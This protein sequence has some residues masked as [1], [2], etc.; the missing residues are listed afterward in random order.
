MD[1]ARSS[2]PSFTKKIL[3]HMK[4]NHKSKKVEVT[5]NSSDSDEDADSFNTSIKLGT[6]RISLPT[7]TK[8]QKKTSFLNQRKRRRESLPIELTIS[9]KRASNHNFSS[10]VPSYK[11]IPKFIEVCSSYQLETCTTVSENNEFSYSSKS[12]NQIDNCNVPLIIEESDAEND[13]KVENESSDPEDHYSNTQLPQLNINDSGSHD[14]ITSEKTPHISQ[15]P[16]NSPSQSSL[17]NI[18]TEIKSTNIPSV[19][20]LDQALQSATLQNLTWN[21]DIKPINSQRKTI[22]V[23]TIEV[24]YGTMMVFFMIDDHKSLIFINLRHKLCSKIQTGV[25]LVFCHDFPPYHL[26]NIDFYTG[27]SK[28]KLMD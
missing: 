14:T 27:I 5:F 21:S 7:P 1:S 13:V 25:E 15:P 26:N 23:S 16:S 4:E 11:S 3:C 18:Y 2:N 10:A 24:L 20:N 9:K 8:N 22:I 17:F 19:L 6:S 12:E 28:I